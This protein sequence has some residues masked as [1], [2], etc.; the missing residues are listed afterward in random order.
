[1]TKSNAATLREIKE[2][3]PEWTT[4]QVQAHYERLTNDEV[5][6]YGEKTMKN[7]TK[8]ANKVPIKTWVKSRIII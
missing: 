8:D 2:R 7:L 6:P 3:Y 5:N 4:K 1:M